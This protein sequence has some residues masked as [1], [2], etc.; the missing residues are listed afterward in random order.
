MYHYISDH[1]N[2]IA[3][4]RD[5]FAEH[6]R[7]LA[8][9]GWRG[10]SLEEAGAFLRDGAFLPEKSVLLTFDDGYLDNYLHAFPLL[11]RY[12]HKGVI[13]AVANRLEEETVPRVPLADVLSGRTA[14]R[15]EVNR[16]IRKNALGYLVR[17]D[18]FCNRGEARA[19]EESGVMAVAAHGRGHYGVCRSP[20]FKNFLRPGNQLRT[21]FLTEDPH[22]WGMPAFKVVP[23]LQ[24]R[25]F[26]PNP[27]LKKAVADLVP[28]DYEQADRFFSHPDNVQ[29]LRRLVEGFAG[30]LGR[31]EN[32]EERKERMWRE[33]A[34]GKKDL[35]AI[36]GHGLDTL[37]WPWGAC[38]PEAGALARQAGF[39][40]FFTVREGANP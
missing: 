23:G 38:C 24:N 29:A 11:H 32:D 14:I 27:D 18:L 40:L 5:R 39:S 3:V 15:D 33:I 9:N 31:L 21:F 17:Q 7:V 4:S 34:W 22:V 20:E 36:L 26:L 13:F 28:Q 10:V 16:P 25:A 1:E 8:E 2:T 30:R 12:G 37:C 6:C 35:E 19:M